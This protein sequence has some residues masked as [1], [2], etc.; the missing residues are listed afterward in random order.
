MKTIIVDYA[1]ISPAV[2]ETIVGRAFP[3]SLCNWREI[4]E[5]SFEFQVFGVSDLAMLEDV[6]AEYV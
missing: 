2:L 4:D 6:L 5:D 1:T 3:Q